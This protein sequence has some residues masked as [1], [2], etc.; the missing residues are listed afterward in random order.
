ME[1]FVYL[2]KFWMTKLTSCCD[3]SEFLFPLRLDEFNEG[4]FGLCGALSAERKT[5][6]SRDGDNSDDEDVE[7]SF[8][9][10]D[11]STVS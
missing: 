2:L 4:T 8:V 3:R 1:G 5:L 6:S 7:C 10:D 11:G 9:L